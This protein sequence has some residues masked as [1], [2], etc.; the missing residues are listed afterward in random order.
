MRKAFCLAFLILASVM[1]GGCYVT[2]DSTGQW[3]ACEEY[4]TEAGLANACYPIAAPF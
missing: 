1:S 3:W 2:Q 4:Q